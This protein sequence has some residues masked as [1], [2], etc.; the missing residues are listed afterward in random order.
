M[1]KVNVVC[2]FDGTVALQDVTDGLLERFADPSW[3]KVEARWLA[4]EFGSRECMA[5]QARLIDVT[6]E[7]IDR[8][9]DSVTIDPAFPAFVDQCSSHE[10][11]TLEI[12]SDGIDYAVRRVL[13]NHGFSGLQV[14]A[15]ALR[16]V[17]P[18]R[19]ELDFPHARPDCRAEAGNCK[20]AAARG[21]AATSSSPSATILIGDGASD[22]CVASSADFVFAKARLLGYCR[23][24]GIRHMAF[25]SFVDINRELT[26]VLESLSLQGGVGHECAEASLE[27]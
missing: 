19:Y 25:E 9:L 10:D 12:N 27:L 7:E 15:N 16:A 21:P 14:R 2:D 3:R 1:S 8:Y 24:K 20:C 4:G 5:R 13:D 17:A 11:V 26:D 18:T 6:V 23:A 22:F